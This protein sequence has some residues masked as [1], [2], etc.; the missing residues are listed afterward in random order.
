MYDYDAVVVGAGVA[1]LSVGALLA[2]AGKK[3]LV[4]ERMKLVGGRATTYKYKV[5]DKEFTADWGGVAHT[6]NF[7]DRGAVGSVY[8][9]VGFPSSKLQDLFLPQQPTMLIYRQ[10]KWEDLRELNKG[11]NKE[12]FKKIIGEIVTMKWEDVDELDTVPFTKW[13]AERTSRASVQDWFATLGHVLTTIPHRVDW[14]T[15][16]LVWIWKRN[17]EVMHSVSSG[18]FIKGGS[19]NLSLPLADYI[20]ETGGDVRLGTKVS[21]ILVDKGRVTG[22]QIGE[23]DPTASGFEDPET[24][25][26]PIVVDTAPVWD[27]MDYIPEGE[28]PHWFVRLINSYRMPDI[29]HSLRG[30]QVG[31]NI[32]LKEEALKDCFGPHQGKEHR[33]CLDMP[34]TGGVGQILIGGAMDPS[35]IID[36]KTKFSFSSFGFNPEI[37]KDKATVERLFEALDKDFAALLPELSDDYIVE[38]RRSPIGGGVESLIDGLARMPYFSGKFKIDN[39][40]PLDGL[41]FA[42]DTVRSRGTGMDASVRSAIWCFNKITGENVPTYLMD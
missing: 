22:V 41:Y 38:R 35:Q 27:I 33:V 21:R 7:L 6:V 42:G 28:F 11:E 17:L 16:E 24:V 9:E 39:V 12:D 19:I 13:I 23:L 14:S 18:A 34:Y 5:G 1:G 25:S 15:G 37:M 40:G 31:Y 2:K 8:K 10:G 29:L 20:K 30:G 32:L 4:L 26:A 36:G 3:V